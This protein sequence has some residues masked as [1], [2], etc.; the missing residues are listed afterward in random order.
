[1]LKNSKGVN[2]EQFIMVKIIDIPTPP[3]NVL[4]TKTDPDRVFIRWSSPNKT[5]CSDVKKYVIQVL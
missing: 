2:E 4:G 5:G 1:M 3:L